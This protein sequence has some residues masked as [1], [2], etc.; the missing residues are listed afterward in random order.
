MK[1]I[2]ISKCIFFGV[3]ISIPIF[4]FLTRR[5]SSST[6]VST[7]TSISDS[8]LKIRPGYPTYDSYFQKQLNKTLNP[9]LRKIWTTRDWDRKI[10]FSQNSSASLKNKLLRFIKVLCIGARMGQEVKAETGQ[11]FG[12]NRNGPGTL[13]AIGGE[14]GDFH[15]QPFDDEAFD[16]NSLTCLITHF[17]RKVRVR[18]SNDFE[19]RRDL[20]VTQWLTPSFYT[21][22]LALGLGNPIDEVIIS[23][24]TPSNCA[25]ASFAPE[26]GELCCFHALA[27]SASE[28]FFLMHTFVLFSLSSSRR[29][30]AIVLRKEVAIGLLRTR[31]AM[32]V[33]S[34]PVVTAEC[35]LVESSGDCRRPPVVVSGEAPSASSRRAAEGK[36]YWRGLRK[37]PE[38][39]L[40]TGPGRRATGEG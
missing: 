19:A 36:G 8:D 6:L 37:L 18:R 29:D 5:N 35:R 17:F 4:L 7:S 22:R 20:R 10:Q 1:E 28:E 27:T 25:E 2:S 33:I 14:E 31:V 26:Y 15:N 3:L 9:K 39:R 23:F 24:S 12:F 34:E 13:P 32:V 11:G 40:P 30:S 38:G 16:L 21:T